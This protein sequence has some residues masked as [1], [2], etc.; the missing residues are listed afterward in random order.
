MEFALLVLI[1]LATETVLDVF[2][3]M[4]PILTNIDKKYNQ[5]GI[6][7]VLGFAVSLLFAFGLNAD[8]FAMFGVE[9]TI[10]Y[11]GMVVTA[12]AASAG[13][14]FVYDRIKKW[15]DTKDSE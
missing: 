9:F 12:L 4:F 3:L 1:A 5:V 2:K 14:K 11:V 8:I 7:Y 15:K 6:F 10:P 13:S